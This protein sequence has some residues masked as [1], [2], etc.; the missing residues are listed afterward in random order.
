MTVDIHLVR[1]RKSAECARS[2]IAQNQ[3]VFRVA[4]FE[5]GEIVGHAESELI[6]IP[7]PRIS[8]Q[9][10]IWEV[11]ETMHFGFREPI[12][13]VRVHVQRILIVIFTPERKQPPVPVYCVEPDW[14]PRRSDVLETEERP[15][16]L[17]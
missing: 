1:K 11:I 13:N 17:G 6:K 12:E 16:P 14:R 2:A 9:I 4:I 15:F 7:Y 5:I 8:T 3:F 10:A